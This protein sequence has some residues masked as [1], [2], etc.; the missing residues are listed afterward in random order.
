MA[1]P[2]PKSLDL[3][4]VIVSHRTFEH[5]GNCLR[6][7]LIEGGLH[8][9]QAEVIVVDNA[10]NDGTVE[11]IGAQ[12]PQVRLI[13]NTE[14]LGFT[15][16][17]NQGI[18]AAGGRNILLLNP[19]T[20][21][22][23]GT[24]A[25]CVAFLEGQPETV[26]AMSC[27]VVSPDGSLQPYCARRLPTPWSESCRALLLDRLFSKSDLFN[28]EP[29]VRWDKTDA[30]P[31][32]A[33]LGAFM[34]IRQTALAQVGGMDERFFMMYEETDLCKR[35]GDKGYAIWYWP[36]AHIVHIGGQS[37]KQEPVITF[38]NSH[39][40]ALVYFAKHYPR[41]VNLLRVILRLGIELKIG[42]LRLNALRKPGDS[43]T[44]SH[45]EMARAARTTLKTCRPI[46]Y[47]GWT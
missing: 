1:D 47:G 40:S 41:S 34:L 6:T 4:V 19:D 35:L 9:L 44:R 45:L 43:Y 36:E 3:S 37:T 14:N 11:M 16:G 13:A 8:G 7:L 39:I 26:G 31:V 12:F 15:R 17:N 20:L 32:P 42:L 10:S 22:P 23:D 25:R 24:L 27:R 46:R 30:R 5:V 29:F 21:V 38:A 28:P 2:V 33:I 18:A